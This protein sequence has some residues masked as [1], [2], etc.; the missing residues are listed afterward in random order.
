[1]NERERDRL[2]VL[3]EIQQGHLKQ[4]EAGRR[5]RLTDR[6]VRQPCYA[7]FGPTLAAEHLAR[8]RLR[9]SRETL[10]GWMSRGGR[11]SGNC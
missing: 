4:V 9:V 2:K 1:M 10:R 6:Q 11:P 3:H 8:H 7:G 5:L